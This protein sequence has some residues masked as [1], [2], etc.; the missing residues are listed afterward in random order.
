M[1]THDFEKLGAFYLGRHHDLAGGETSDTP[2]LYDSRDLTTHAVCVGMTGSG[3]TGLCISL[4]EE[5]AIDGVPA[6]AIDPKGDLGNLL[7]TFPELAAAEFRPWINEDDARRK[8]HTPDEYAAQQAELWRN[9]L[10][11]WGQ[12]PER[13]R[14]LKDAAEVTLYT[15]G[16]DAG[17]PVSI[18]SSF[19]APPPAGRVDGDAL[20]DRVSATT[21]SLL[22]LMGI[23]ADPLQSREHILLSNLLDH[24]WRRGE[25]LDLPGL[26]RGIQ[27][28]PMER[29]GVLDLES[30]YSGGDRFKL[31]MRLNNL[32]ASP[33]FQAWLQG[34]PLDVQ[35][36]LYTASGKPRIAVFSIAHLSD[37]E[38]MFAV[39]LLLGQV[40]S[41]MRGRPGTTSLRALLY[42]D[43]IFGFCPPI[44]EPPSKKPLLTLLKQARAYG[45]GVVLA[46]QNPVDLDYKGLSN[47]GTWMIGR[48]QTERDKRRVMEGLEGL[49]AGGAAFSK[50]EMEQTLAGLGKRVFLMHNVHDAGPAIFHTRWAMSYLRGP[51]TREQ[52]RAL[53]AA[54]PLEG[55]G[56]AA[57]PVARVAP[58]APVAAPAGRPVLP[59]TVPQVFLPARVAGEFD[60]TPVLVGLARVQYVDRKT[61]KLKHADEVA[62]VHPLGGGAD[63]DW[64]RAQPVELL[65]EELESAPVPGAGFGEVPDGAE[66][67]TS[68]RTWKKAL[69]DTLY[70][71]RTCEV[72][73]SPTYGLISDPGEPEAE[74][75]IR[76][77]ELA[78]ERRDR[79]TDELR[80]KYDKRVARLEERLR[81]ARQRLESE[82]DQAAGQKLQTAISLGTTVLSA[83]LGRKAFSRGTVGRAGTAAR[84]LTRGRKEK[85][86]VRR[87]SENV[88]ALQVQ[89]EE[90]NVELENELEELEERFDPLSEKLESTALRPR[91]S[92]VEVRLVALG[93]NP[94]PRT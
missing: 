22:G 58:A 52:I 63:V 54:R 2:L 90:L 59:P 83:F 14:R 71:G 57:A 51:L 24:H 92:D 69:S 72:L 40:L 65:R 60:Y 7:L 93:W 50:Q 89:L 33:G 84:G 68:Y 41:W 29:I 20:R 36:L 46:T 73:K 13:I 53:T 3:K 16:S 19:T 15:P 88:E 26:I 8:G 18:L 91:R 6:I 48:L 86:D 37:S 77:G 67:S 10:A 23:D 85:E 4:L 49:A 94:S 21:S 66:K 30:F 27:D 79:L 44:G 34:E 9:G 62:L 35:S 25:D 31:A 1:S 70:R 5:A 12:G 75:R 55:S 80:R 61:K 45:V 82:K 42:M 81:K 47:T 87:A 38:R 56:A 32:L 11:S 39:S 28:P 76:L 64:S 43:E 17:V 74:F 78:R